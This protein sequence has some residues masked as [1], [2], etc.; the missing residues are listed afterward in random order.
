MKKTYLRQILLFVIMV[1]TTFISHSQCTPPVI[2]LGSNPS[3]CSGN[4]APIPYTLLS[5]SANQY[6]IDWNTIPDLN[7]VTL[8][9]GPT[10]LLRNLP[11]TSGMYT[12]LVY[13]RNTPGCESIGYPV[14]VNI[15][16]QPTITL[17]TNSYVVCLG[18]ST[19]SMPYSYTNATQY[20]IDWNGAANTGGFIDVPYTSIPESP[21]L[22]ENIPA[23][24]GTYSGVL[25]F[26]IDECE[27][28]YGI[29][30]TMNYVSSGTIATNQVICNGGDPVTLTDPVASTG[31]GTLTDQWQISTDNLNFTNIP[32]ATIHWYDPPGG[33]TQTTYFRKVATSTLNGFSCASNSNTI[34]IA[35]NSVNSGSISGD[36]TICTNGGNQDPIAFTV[37]TPA[38]GSGTLTY[39]WQFSNNNNTFYDVSGALAPVYNP[40]PN[41]GHYFRRVTTSSLN[42]VPCDA[43]SNTLTITTIPPVITGTIAIEG[44]GSN[45]NQLICNGGNLN[46]LIETSPGEGIS[47]SYQWQNYI[48]ST[49]TDISGANN[50]S[51]NPPPNITQNTG[52]RR[53]A[54]STLNGVSCSN[55]SNTLGAI[56]NVVGGSIGNNQIICS[57]GNP[58]AF[59]EI[60]P[61]L[62][63]ATYQWQSSIDNTTFSNIYGATSN[64]YNVPSGL[65]QT[66]YYRRVTTSNFSVSGS[67]PQSI[68]C[69]ENRNTVMVTVNS[70]PIIE[71]N[72][73]TPSKCPGSNG[74]SLIASGA[75][76]YIWSP[77]T[78]LS[79]T[80]GSSVIAN[81]TATTTYTVTATDNNTCS[82]SMPITVTVNPIPTVTTSNKTICSGQST[83]V[84]LTS[85]ISGTSYSW[86]VYSK[87]ATISGVTVSSTTYTTNPINHTLTN[88]S[89]SAT[90][91]VVYRVTPTANGCIGNYKDITV[92]V[93]ANNITG[94]SV[95]AN[96]T[97]CPNGDPVA[98]TQ[99]TA[100]TGSGTLSYQ[101]Q[102]SL[103][104]ITYNNISGATATTYNVP[105]GLI[106]TTYYKRLTSA[107]QN[108]ITCSAYNS[109]PIIVTVKPTPIVVITPPTGTKCPTGTISLTASGASSY[110]WSPSSGLSSSTG[111]SVNCD[112]NTTTTYT[113]TGTTNACPG[114]AQVTVT[115]NPLPVVTTVNKTICSGESAYLTL[116]SSVSNTS[117]SW[118]VLSKSS[119][120][121]G[122]S[123]GES[124]TTG[125]IYHTLTNSSSSTNGTVV[126]RVTPT[127]NGCTGNYKDITVTVKPRGT[128]S[129]NQL[130]DLCSYGYA[131]LQ[132]PLGS[133][134]VWSPLIMPTGRTVRIYSFGTYSVTYTNSGGCTETASITLVYSGGPCI[135]VRR[136][137]P[138]VDEPGNDLDESKEFT[139]HPNPVNQ[140]LTVQ[141]PVAVKKSTSVV[142][143]DTFGKIAHTSEFKAGE[144]SKT[145]STAEIAN[146]IYMLEVSAPNGNLIRKVIISH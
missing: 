106:Q 75:S 46:P 100:S 10:I 25:Y 29:N 27:V 49:W 133:N 98:F 14:S 103:D 72:P 79:S 32:G 33:V 53:V 83:D 3:I 26:K 115:V 78:G 56:V 43:I 59:T 80:T 117:Y 123:V 119:T 24:L 41:S 113:I 63:T 31:I 137:S 102:S 67:P 18:T 120:I 101:W 107:T 7:W 35:V 127:A 54:I 141:L 90:G 8:P 23:S 146:G 84:T 145:I 47:L 17:N 136:A 64:T 44:L 28:G 37:S 16:T 139:T 125:T 20:R 91:T 143:Y 57:G 86:Y 58:I 42:T 66:S 130:N 76:T 52:F 87:G 61:P 104:N 89:T 77:S 51:Y 60:N 142:L 55:P 108:G 111:A 62:S 122:T 34:T 116:S 50:P 13:L 45:Y 95:A 114:T 70:L 19:L 126:Y 105:S 22:V 36:Q 38:T 74:I 21:I 110:S 2:S 1:F 131:D 129:I 138:N 69:S 132:A 88:S 134:Y 81:P 97:I 85:N 9:P 71:V 12:G 144:K 68:T 4:M 124:N 15:T 30:V 128:G 109:T 135:L 6:R 121:S 39:K 48:N 118:S 94:G 112:A 73:P 11:A 65:I 96:Q 93:N 92:T 40:P 140:T 82:T 99:T 5:G